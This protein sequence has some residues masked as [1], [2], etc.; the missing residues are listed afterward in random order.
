MRK[1]NH[2][3]DNKTRA[4]PHTRTL[5]HSL[6]VPYTRTHLIARPKIVRAQSPRVLLRR[7]PLFAKNDV[8]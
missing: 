8:P 2:N 1:H 7:F 3:R 4:H 6:T 5:A